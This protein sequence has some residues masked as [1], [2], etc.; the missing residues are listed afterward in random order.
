MNTFNPDMEVK[1]I[2]LDAWSKGKNPT[3]TVRM[4]DDH[5]FIISTE[6]VIAAFGR[7]TYMFNAYLT[8]RADRKT[9]QLSH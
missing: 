5:G 7:M 9:A 1:D 8:K 6:Y 2:I 3:E 4:A